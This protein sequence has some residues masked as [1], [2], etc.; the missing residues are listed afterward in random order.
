[1]N[2]CCLPPEQALVRRIL[3]AAASALGDMHAAGI[4]CVDLKPENLVLDVRQ[5]GAAQ[6]INGLKLPTTTSH[7]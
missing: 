6:Y 1:M 5:V 4:L 3:T 7:T 2:Q